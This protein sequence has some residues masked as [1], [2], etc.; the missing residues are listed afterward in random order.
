MDN[1]LEQKTMM[2]LEI[3]AENVSADDYMEHY[4]E[5][6][7]EWVEGN[8]LKM[9]PI[10]WTH[11]SILDY[12]LILLK[13]FISAK[14]IRGKIGHDTFVMRLDA[15]NSR[16]EPDL[17]VILGDNLD[18]LKETYMDGPADICIEIVSPGT[19]QNDYG[20]KLVEYEK[21]GVQEYWI[22]DPIRRDTRFLRLNAE[23]VYQ[24]V[25]LDDEGHYSTPL[26]LGL[27]LHVPTLWQEELPDIAAIWAYIQQL[28]QSS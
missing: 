15:V 17:M 18:N 19:V 14:N 22:L 7:H 16:R 4:A 11:N 9:S 20:A 13:T 3:V 27:K 28:T 21:G 23:G 10:S 1:T 6:H 12:L 8:V 26:L 5:S 24:S 2:G 25:A